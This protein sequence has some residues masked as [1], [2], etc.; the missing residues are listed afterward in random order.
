MIL[1]LL[2]AC[3]N[4]N[5][6]TATTVEDTAVVETEDTAEDTAESEDTGE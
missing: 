2:L 6:D 5:E 1:Y 4:K 3:G